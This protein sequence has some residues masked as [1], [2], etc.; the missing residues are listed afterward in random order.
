MT[1]QDNNSGRKER[2]LPA[3]WTKNPFEAPSAHVDDV[4]H[5][6]DGTLLGEPNRVEA[7][8]GSAW[9]SEGWGL[10][11]EATGLWIGIVIAMFVLFV[12]I[13]LIPIAG[14]LATYVLGP[15]ISGG[16]MLGC[17]N[18]DAG[19]GLGFGHLFA[20]FQ[21]NFGQL[22]LVGVLYL[23]GVF[24]I[25]IGAMAIAFGGS[26]GAVFMGGGAAPGVATTSIALAFLVGFLLG[27]PLVMA[28][29]F[30]PALV[31]LNELSA[32]DAM[33]RSFSGCWRNMMPFLVYGLV[34]IVLG[35]VATLPFGLGWLALV[36]VMVCSTYAAY[37]E[38]FVA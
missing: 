17:R 4:R 31:V 26:M 18:L 3:A 7:G 38:I 8:R 16:L 1:E 12:G 24:V 13:G 36:P 6:G 35:I 25:A 9:W 20:G 33:K 22:A 2:P 10:F 28:I 5:V 34:G 19:E 30:A 32:V 23:G 37:K 29:W 27:M 21:K 15:V 11:R 14:S